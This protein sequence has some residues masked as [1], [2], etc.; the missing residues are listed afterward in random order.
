MAVA[1]L[2]T[3][4]R[5]TTNCR[6]AGRML[7]RELSA[8]VPNFHTNFLTNLLTALPRR[9]SLPKLAAEKI[10]ILA[11]IFLASRIIFRILHDANSLQACS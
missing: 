4:S 2:R 11:R 9:S 7:R 8:T 1:R 3:P 5:R 6:G 10:F